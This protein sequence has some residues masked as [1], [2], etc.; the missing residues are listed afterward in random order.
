MPTF[1]IT[2]QAERFLQFYLYDGWEALLSY[3]FSDLLILLYS[4]WR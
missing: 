4:F 1:S 2:M 3:D